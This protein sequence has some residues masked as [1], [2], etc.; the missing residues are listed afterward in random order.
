MKFYFSKYIQK[1]FLLYN[2]SSQNIII[3]HKNYYELNNV[4]F[5]KKPITKP[6]YYKCSFMCTFRVLEC[7]KHLSQTLHL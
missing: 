1:V 3:V 6:R 4:Q 5:T 7:L 2:N